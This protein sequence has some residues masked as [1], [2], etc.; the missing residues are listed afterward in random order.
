VA[1]V[2]LLAAS[3]RV[4]EMVGFSAVDSMPIRLRQN[5]V[6]Q[7]AVEPVSSA[8]PQDSAPASF[9]DAPLTFLSTAPQDSLVQLPGIGPVLAARIVNARAGKRLFTTWDELLSVPGIGPKTLSRL[10]RLAGAAE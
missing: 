8:R 5:L 9:R 1:A 6:R 10:R 7:P 2:L 4:I 3:P